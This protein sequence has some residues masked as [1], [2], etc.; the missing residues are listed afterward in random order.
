MLCHSLQDVEDAPHFIF[1]SPAHKHVWDKYTNHSQQNCTI[2]D[3]IAKCDSNACGGF[4]RTLS[5]GY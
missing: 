3:F 5:V 4:L 1:D 2:P